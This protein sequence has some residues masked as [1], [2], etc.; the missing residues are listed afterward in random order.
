MTSHYDPD[1]DLP[2]SRAFNDMRAIR[3]NNR[4]KAAEAMPKFTTPELRLLELKGLMNTNINEYFASGGADEYARL[5]A[6]LRRK[7]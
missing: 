4:R 6:E 1:D 5:E 3:R 7:S 2:N